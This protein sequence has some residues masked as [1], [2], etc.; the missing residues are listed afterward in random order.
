MIRI[1]FVWFL[2]LGL[3]HGVIPMSQGKTVTLDFEVLLFADLC[4]AA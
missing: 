2:G 1:W 4:G 3:T